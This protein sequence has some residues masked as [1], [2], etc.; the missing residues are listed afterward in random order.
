MV[1]NRPLEALHEVAWV[2]RPFAI[3][4]SLIEL[5]YGKAF[6]LCYL[7]IQLDLALCRL[8]K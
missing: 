4:Y 2:M 6:P 5:F 3:G 7:P 8:R 1:R